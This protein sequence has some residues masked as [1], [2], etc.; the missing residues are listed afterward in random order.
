MKDAQDEKEKPK[1]RFDPGWTA[2]VWMSRELSQDSGSGRAATAQTRRCETVMEALTLPS[3]NVLFHMLYRNL[4]QDETF[5]SDKQHEKAIESLRFEADRVAAIACVVAWVKK[6][7]K[8]SLAQVMGT[9]PTKGGSPL[10]AATRLQKVIRID[11]PMDL[12]T[13]LRRLVQ[14]V[15]NK[16]NISRLAG[17]IWR[18]GPD[19]TGQKVRSRW[20][21]DYYDYLS[22]DLPP[23]PLRNETAAA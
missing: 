16:A 13:P 12:V 20:C 21:L 15:G 5:R 23:L 19:E 4:E 8:K 18:W 17:D 6:D 2:K 1:K 22:N 10:V 7:T 9:P 14:Q 3:T 11:E